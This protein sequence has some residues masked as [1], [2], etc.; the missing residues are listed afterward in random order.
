M[1]T[2]GTA[3]FNLDFLGLAEEAWEQAG[4]RLAGGYDLRT[5]RRSLNLLFQE[6]ANRGLNLWTLE[7]VEQVLTASDPTY[8][9]PA[10]TV[11]LIDA[12]IRINAG[13]TSQVD[14][15]LNRMS[16]LEYS[17]LTNKLITSRPTRIV[18][19]RQKDAPEVILWPVP[20]AALTYTLVYW[21]IRRIEDT[22]AVANLTLD[23]PTRFLP[24]M[25]AGLAW[26]IA[27]KKANTD[28]SLITRLPQ[29]E[30]EYEKQ[31]TLAAGEDRDKTTTKLLPR[32]RGYR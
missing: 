5:T 27:Q 31:W 30:R 20:D 29:L 1:A 10:D 14:Y 26:R 2:S 22:G 16:V 17:A 6:W 19:D 23:A 18:I 3:T 11:D 12:S 28:T 9:L 15:N 25:T 21:R 32:L 13:T 7:E 8:T 4:L 24:A